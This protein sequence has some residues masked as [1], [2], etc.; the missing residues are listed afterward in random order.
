MQVLSGSIVTGTDAELCAWERS[1]AL[2]D[3]ILPGWAIR[4]H[5][6]SSATVQAPERGPQEAPSISDAHRLRWL[7][8]L[9]N[10]ELVDMARAGLPAEWWPYAPALEGD[11]VAAV[12]VVPAAARAGARPKAHPE[13]EGRL[14]SGQGVLGVCALERVA[15]WQRSGAPLLPAQEDKDDACGG[16]ERLMT[17]DRCDD[18]VPRLVWGVR[19]QWAGP[20]LSV[21]SALLLAVRF[22]KGPEA[23]QLRQGWAV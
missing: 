22:P 18:G 2:A 8:T 1:A 17:S 9:R 19:G 20:L 15:G 11:A 16:G 6:N 5:Y 14:E 4:L 21:Q 13:Q 12:F 3:K 10:I 7:R 23:E